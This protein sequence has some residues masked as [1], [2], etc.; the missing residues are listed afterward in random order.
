MPVLEDL[1]QRDRRHLQAATP[2]NLQGIAQHDLHF[3]GSWN[4]CMDGRHK[5]T[6][7]R[8]H[9]QVRN[10]KSGENACQ[11]AASL[12]RLVAT[13]SSS[14][15]RQQQQQ[16]KAVGGAHKHASRPDPLP[17]RMGRRTHAHT[18]IVAAPRSSNWWLAR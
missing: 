15:L 4:T 6:Q 7:E 18:H 3:N 9:Q 13:P 14:R 5:Q 11:H 1:Y 2:S 17:A 8:Q 10:A 12:A 16:Q